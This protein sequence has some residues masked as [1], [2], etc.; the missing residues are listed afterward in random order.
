MTGGPI[1]GTFCRGKLAVPDLTRTRA[2]LFN[3]AGISPVS[4]SFRK[5]ASRSGDSCTI[6]STC[7]SLTGC[8]PYVTPGGGAEAAAEN[9]GGAAWAGIPTRGTTS[10]PT[11]MRNR[12]T[13]RAKGS[14]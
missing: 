10:V 3:S 7:C 9:A 8:H 4:G 14:I 2:T 5:A 1:C 13:S 6:S 11:R 12:R